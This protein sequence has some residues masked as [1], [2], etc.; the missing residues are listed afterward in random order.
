MGL[1]HRSPQLMDYCDGNILD[2]FLSSFLELIKIHYFKLPL[3]PL[4]MTE[5]AFSE[6]EISIH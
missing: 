1:C 6:R 5:I 2:T 3:T 4:I